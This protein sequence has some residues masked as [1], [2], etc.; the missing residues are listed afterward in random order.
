MR[1]PSVRRWNIQLL[2]YSGPKV[3]GMLLRGSLLMVVNRRVPVFL[4]SHVR[5]TGIRY[6]RL[7][8]WSKIED[9]VEMQCVSRRG[10]TIGRFSSVGRG[11]QIMPSGYY[12]GDVGDG[13]RMGENS[14]I[15][16]YSYIGCSGYVD[17][18]NNVITG[19]GVKV[20]AQN[21]VYSETETPI[22]EQGVVQSGITIQDDC[23]LGAAC[24]ILDGV[25][26]GPHSVV[27]AG[28]IVTRDVPAG[29]VVGGVPARVLRWRRGFGAA[30]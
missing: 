4:G 5:L 8:S 22:R 1:Q 25:R 17:I 21:H 2:S 3:V 19:P 28:A 16:P 29:A 18:G 24:V 26:I 14:A 12:S 13:M 11:T 27:A 7:A 15:G 6:L 30:P 9:L 23:W 20:L 10:I